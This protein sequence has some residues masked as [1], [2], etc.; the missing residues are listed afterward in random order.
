MEIWRN[1]RG[2]C[3]ISKG[4]QAWCLRPTRKPI[5]QPYY[6]VLVPVWVESWQ[7]WVWSGSC[8]TNGC[9][10]QKSTPTTTMRRS[11]WPA[12]HLVLKKFIW[13]TC[14][15]IIFNSSKCGI[16]G[17]GWILL[18]ATVRA[19]FKNANKAWNMHT[20]NWKRTHIL[21]TPHSD[22]E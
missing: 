4:L 13:K 9:T 20:L 3:I 18:Q 8:P 7:M 2:H 5:W 15:Y 10:F 22:A 16:I 1:K 17:K 19:A 14:F 21:N 12:T 11:C 6:F